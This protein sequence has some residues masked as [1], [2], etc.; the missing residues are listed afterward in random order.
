MNLGVIGRGVSSGE[1]PSPER[2]RQ[3]VSACISAIHQPHNKLLCGDVKVVLNGRLR[4]ESEQTLDRFQRGLRLGP[5]EFKLVGAAPT[6]STSSGQRANPKLG[7]SGS[8]KVFPLQ[9]TAVGRVEG[10]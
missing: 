3:I 1:Q 6:D 5:G 2:I 10:D 9:A 8:Q 4:W 7:Q